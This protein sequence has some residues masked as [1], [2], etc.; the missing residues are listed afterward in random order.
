[1]P[2]DSPSPDDVRRLTKILKR[3]GATAPES[4]AGSQVSEGIPQ[5]AYFVFL[6]QAWQAILEP[7]NSRQWFKALRQAAANFPEASL[8]KLSEMI[9]HFLALGATEKNLATLIQLVQYETLNA[10]CFLLDD[11]GFASDVNVS[12][13]D[14]WPAVRWALHQVDENGHVVAHLEGLHEFCDGEPPDG[15]RSGFR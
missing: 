10:L 8:G 2:V 7:Q 11:G 6:K 12:D 13:G 14:G 5:L 9:D 15:K 1:M 3:L 4:L